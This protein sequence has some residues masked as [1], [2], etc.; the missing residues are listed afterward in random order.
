MQSRSEVSPNII[1]NE[2]IDE[3]IEILIQQTYNVTIPSI[4]IKFISQNEE[5]FEKNDL[6]SF[7]SQFGE[8]IKIL[9]YHKFS[10]VLYKSIYI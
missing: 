9:Q 3:Q 6:L 8:V 10:I 5:N 1:P 7:Y 2:I 4:V